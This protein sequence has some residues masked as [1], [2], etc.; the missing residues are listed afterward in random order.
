MT[1]LALVA[2][3]ARSTA[4]KRRDQAEREAAVNRS[5][6]LANAAT[7]LSD[8]DGPGYALPLALEAVN[9]ERPPTES[10]STLQ[11]IALKAGTRI[12]LREQGNAI[13]AIAIS[14][15]SRLGLSGGCAA[16]EGEVCTQ[17]EL[18]LWDLETR[19]EV[20]RFEGH[21]DW[22]NDVAFGSDGK[23][24]L[25]GSDDKTLIL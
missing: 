22:V 7:K 20:R 18:I 23:T 10:V 21:T 15:D 14:P 12:I 2:M 1:V 17:G 11:N 4:Q 24:I 19:A 6:V 5:L 3:S 25:S 16:L 8:T 9:M 13:K